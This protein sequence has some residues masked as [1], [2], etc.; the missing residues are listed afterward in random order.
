MDLYVPRERKTALLKIA[1]AY[2]P[3]V[4]V[5]LVQKALGFEDETECTDFLIEMKVVFDPKDPRS[6]ECKLSCPVLIQARTESSN[7]KA[8]WAK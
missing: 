8:T 1:Q 3:S 6:M 4:K 2:R 5:T 7:T